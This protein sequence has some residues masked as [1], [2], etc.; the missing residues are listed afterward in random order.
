MTVATTRVI[1]NISGC[2]DLPVLMDVGDM[3]LSLEA[4]HVQVSD[5]RQFVILRPFTRPAPWEIREWLEAKLKE[6]K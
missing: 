1:A 2:L 5:G 6:L 3:W 4:E